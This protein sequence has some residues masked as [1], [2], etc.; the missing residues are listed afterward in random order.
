MTADIIQARYD[1]LDNIA[2]RFGREAENTTALMQQVQ[3]GVDALRQG[4][5]EGQGG[6]AFLGEMETAVFPVIQRLTEALSEANTATQ[7]LRDIIRTAEEEAASFFNGN[8]NSGN[9]GGAWLP[10]G[11]SLGFGG[12][13][14]SPSAGGAT[15]VNNT[16]QNGVAK[17]T[18]EEV[19]SEEYMEDMIGSH[20][21]GENSEE[22]N[23]VMEQASEQMRS[24]GRISPDLLDKM[25]DLRGED[26]EAFR[27]QYQTFEELWRNAGI[28]PGLNL[29]KHPDFLGSTVS[30]RYGKVVGDILGV[31]PV[32]GSLL[33][34]AGGLV[35]PGSESYQ[36]APND[37]IGY[38]GV[39]H[40]AAGYLK[41]YQ[42][43]GPGYDYLDRENFN[44]SDDEYNGQI[45][46]ISWWAS[47][48]E[49]NI[50][51]P[52]RNNYLDIPGV[53]SFLDPLVGNALGNSLN[54]IR[55][56]IYGVEGRLEV[57]DGIQDVFDGNF[58][59]GARNI[60]DG[61][62]TIAGGFLRTQ[63]E[64]AVGRPVVE[65]VI[66]FSTK[67]FGWP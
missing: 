66:D 32:F 20:V 8:R 35:G 23:T 3:R 64:N 62:S 67:I 58:V 36:P 50:N 53:P 59:A 49:L 44:F 10:D 63:A 7:T 42:D 13:G 31:D 17:K 51:I 38:H 18:P 61:S 25:A 28:K 47:H 30:L 57:V 4:G 11:T 34:P 43:V 2:N 39:F 22:L 56:A 54:V 5:W 14:A 60:I 46:G 65:G 27:E 26:R 9:Q 40:D 1:Q 48:P 52:V 21:P 15:S 41:R 16:L 55:P 6:A 12:N 24:G 19:F 29:D 33:S 37:A 45:G